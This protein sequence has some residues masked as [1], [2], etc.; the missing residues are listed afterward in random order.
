M[1]VLFLTHIRERH[2]VAATVCYLRATIA[3]KGRVVLESLYSSS[4][5]SGR[6]R[7]D[8]CSPPLNTPPHFW[9]GTEKKKIEDRSRSIDLVE[10]EDDHEKP[11]PKNTNDSA[12]SQTMIVI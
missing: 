11:P 12:D 8:R 6:I 1:E 2:L 7:L 5:Y 9:V 10:Y 4:G 3:C